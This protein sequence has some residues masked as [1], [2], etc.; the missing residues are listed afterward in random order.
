LLTFIVLQ[1]G[2]LL[3][4]KFFILYIFPPPPPKYSQYGSGLLFVKGEIL[5]FVVLET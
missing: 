2:L 5:V 1:V 4:E 3:V